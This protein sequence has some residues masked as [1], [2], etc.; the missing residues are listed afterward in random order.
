MGSC[1]AG[2]WPAGFG[3]RKM[4]KRQGGLC[5][6]KSSLRST[7]R[8]EARVTGCGD[9]C[10]PVRWA[11]ALPVLGAQGKWPNS[12]E[13]GS[14]RLCR[15]E[16]YTTTASKWPNSSETSFASLWRAL[17]AFVGQEAYTTTASPFFSRYSD[18]SAPS[19]L[20]G[21][22]CIGREPEAKPEKFAPPELSKGWPL[23]CRLWEHREMAGGLHHNRVKMAIGLFRR[24]FR[25]A[26]A[27]QLKEG[28][29]QG[30][31]Q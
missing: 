24:R 2:L 16:A 1:K 30:V 31:R 28:T 5:P 6:P 13:T 7:C 25:A 10:V 22:V 8:L 20:F 14:A 26:K 15:P 12:R 17:P 9:G 3:H 23:A 18:A 19:G 27:V 29:G 11:S 4:A 21:C